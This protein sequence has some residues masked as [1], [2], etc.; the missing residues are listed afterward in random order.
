MTNIQI[1]EL[2]LQYFKGIRKLDI[3]LGYTTNISADNRAGK[4]TVFDA[5]TWLL[6]GKDSLGRS[7]FEIKT[8]DSEGN[9]IPDVDHSV[10]GVITVNGAT[11]K[12]RR[13]YRENWVKRRG[14]SETV[15]QGH[16]TECFFDGVPVSVSEY[17]K[18]IAGICQEDL[19]KLITDP[20][21]FNTRIDKRDRRK[22]LMDMAGEITPESV[23]EGN[24]IFEAMLAK[25]EGRTVEAYKAMI[26][27]QKKEIKN[28]LANI[29]PRIDEHHQTMPEEL[30][31]KQLESDLTTVEAALEQARLFKVDRPK[32]DQ[33]AIEQL[34]N[35]V[36]QLNVQIL[37]E[38]EKKNKEATISADQSNALANRIKQELGEVRS[39]YRKLVNRI[40]DQEKQQIDITRRLTT[41]TE[42]LRRKQEEY[43]QVNAQTYTP[44]HEVICPIFKHKCSDPTAL[45]RHLENEE[46]SQRDFATNKQ[47]LLAAIS[48]DGTELASAKK[49]LAGQLEDL[50]REMKKTIEEKTAL[51]AQINKFET[52]LASTPQVEPKRY[53]GS[54]LEVTIA[55]QARIT[56]LKGQI[57]T[58]SAPKDTAAA[59]EAE[60]ENKRMIS[61]LEA[62]K[63]NIQAKLFDRTKIAN[64]KERITDLENQ[65]KELAHTINQIELDEHTLLQISKAMASELDIR[66]NGK[67]EWV[68]FRL[69]ETQI[70]GGEV[71]TCEALINGVPYASANNEARIN[72]G[73]DIINAL[74]DHYKIS[75][76]I[77]IDNRESVNWLQNSESQ[78]INLTVSQDKKLTVSSS[79]SRLQL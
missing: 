49:H 1:R 6:F 62:Q 52:A 32:A 40:F 10:E 74:S 14:S 12:L 24:P 26:G 29:T 8:L 34:Y 64:K 77:W 7:D 11:T 36:V 57:E 48:A 66:I 41:T 31:W 51:E 54:D 61:E 59:D 78:I 63:A 17:N 73:I 19:F 21:H 2:R 69:F 20:L 58:L 76:P 75:A 38:V 45:E 4:T 15:L 22:I 71:E 30:D 47:T 16:T 13:V 56:D 53:T 37:Q 18:L 9:T 65:R 5:F 42:D 3:E 33:A 46:K 35:E 23:S 72:A 60:K 25:M 68:K 44:G 28:E 70:N 79:Q 43:L 39:Q 50:E 27:S 55:M 67:F